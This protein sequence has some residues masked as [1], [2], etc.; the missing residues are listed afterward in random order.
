MEDGVGEFEIP[1]TKIFLVFVSLVLK[2]YCH[3]S[4]VLSQQGDLAI[5]NSLGVINSVR[6]WLNFDWQHQVVEISKL[7][8][9]PE[10]ATPNYEECVKTVLKWV[11]MTRMIIAHL[12]TATYIANFYPILTLCRE[13]LLVPWLAMSAVKNFVLEII[14]FVVVVLLYL[15]NHLS[16]YL[17]CEFFI[18]KFATLAPA[19]YN[20]FT[21]SSFY[22]ELKMKNRRKLPR[23]N[24]SI[25]YRDSS[26][27]YKHPNVIIGLP[28]QTV[29]FYYPRE[30]LNP[31]PGPPKRA[32]SLINY[33]H[34][35]ESTIIRPSKSL[36]KILI[37]KREI[38]F[39]VTE[40][41]QHHVGNSRE[42]ITEGST[43][44]CDCSMQDDQEEVMDR[45]SE[46]ITP[47]Q[48]S[49]L[50]HDWLFKKMNNKF[51]LS[52]YTNLLDQ[53]N[54]EESSRWSS[55]EDTGA[56]DSCT[57]IIKNPVGQVPKTSK[58]SIK[59]DS[60][61]WRRRLEIIGSSFESTL[62]YY[63]QSYDC[64]SSKLSNDLGS[65]RSWILD[66]MIITGTVSNRK[67]S[68]QGLKA[69]E[70]GADRVE[71]EALKAYNKKTLWEDRQRVKM[72]M[73]KLRKYSSRFS[74]DEGCEGEII[75]EENKQVMKMESVE[76]IKE[77][78]AG[79]DWSLE[80]FSTDFSRRDEFNPADIFDDH[81]NCTGVTNPVSD[82]MNN[83]VELLL[84]A[85]GFSD[86]RGSGEWSSGIYSPYEE[87][88]NVFFEIIKTARVRTMKHD[89]HCRRTDDVDYGDNYWRNV[90]YIT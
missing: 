60:T 83:T 56:E 28:M 81:E 86:R 5:M 88:P 21:L 42:S 30:P 36:S 3:L 72:D 44:S 15:Q 53:Y 47:P 39:S 78:I 13:R 55:G 85:F 70:K 89:C 26:I 20:W 35:Q 40:K 8:L 80:S 57:T 32:T 9:S 37:D 59:I 1:R 16:F 19:V 27:V 61:Q 74:N 2:F 45:Y 79:L 17:L 46:P 50:P 84:F 51:V 77:I 22:T 12:Y 69:R 48:S 29:N 41:A 7:P 18:H 33:S 67:K 75:R 31:S 63:N 10:N 66:G 38:D 87:I 49:F 62:Q 6:D 11:V 52:N 76:M 58:I 54:D 90:E 65:S 14:V 24:T 25:F 68:I 82:N 64:Q 43:S 23:L 73:E 71:L 34:P 4:G